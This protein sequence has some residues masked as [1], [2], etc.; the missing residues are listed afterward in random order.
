MSDGFQQ[1]KDLLSLFVGQKSDLK[2]FD[3]K[4]NY[5]MIAG[6]PHY[7]N[8]VSNILAFFF[9]PNEAHGMGDLWI[10]SLAECYFEV[11]GRKIED[12]DVRSVSREVVC[13]EQK[14]IDLLLEM[15]ESIIVIENKIGAAPDNPWELYHKTV[16]E[17]YSTFLGKSKPIEILLSIKKEKNICDEEK[18]YE[19]YNI[20]YDMLIDRVQAKMGDYIQSA[21]YKW[22][23]FMNEFIVN[24]RRM[25]MSI[26][27]EIDPKWNR[28][29]EENNTT[30]AAFLEQM[31]NDRTAKRVWLDSLK[32][33]IEEYLQEG[34][35]G[36]CGRYNSG[37]YSSVYIDIPVK[38][39]DR[40][41]T[42]VLEPYIMNSFSDHENQKTTI[43]YLPI[44][45]RTNKKSFEYDRILGKLGNRFTKTINKDPKSGWGKWYVLKKYDMTQGL[46]LEGVM[47]DIVDIIKI[48]EEVYPTT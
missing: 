5:F 44:W 33:R 42:L 7:E 35:A 32:L 27:P 30:I 31:E 19:F 21:N 48:I 23:V 17:M 26:N 11:S 29:I 8:V 45:C 2:K 43:L 16:I 4:D 24:I 15:Q 22:F 47:G 36:N 18:G 6:Y 40:S 1:Y 14:R 9:Q 41:E 37:S 34:H 38:V 13:E 10:S 39:G 46:N 25:I 28:F 12:N 3:Y 20:C